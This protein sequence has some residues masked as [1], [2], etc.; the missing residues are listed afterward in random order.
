[1]AEW[2]PLTEVA[3]A[4]GF[5]ARPVARVDG[6]VRD[7]TR[8][9]AEVAAWR[10]AFEAVAGPRVALYFDDTWTF[11]CALYG[12]WHAGKH[13][14]LPGD[15]QPATLQRVLPGVD[16]CAG[17]LPGAIGPREGAAVTPLAA[18]DAQR[19]GLVVHTSGS[20]GEPVEIAKSLAQL[21]AEMDTLQAAFGA[22]LAARDGAEV[23]ATVSHQ[24]I[25]G[26]LFHALWPLASGRV[27]V[28][29]RLQYPE[30]MAAQLGGTSVL[31]TSPA[32]LKRLPDTLD[33][34]AA[35]AGLLA[36][37]SSGGPLPPEAAATTLDLL[38]HSPTEVYGSSETG[39]IAWR[40]RAEHGDRWT[41]L[42][43]IDWRA[44]DEG[45]LSVRSRHLPD[46]AWFE[47]A[48]RVAADGDG[49][50][51]RGRADRIVKIEEKRVSLTA[52]EQA[53]LA[54]GDLAEARVIELPGDTG[55]RL[56]VVGVPT[57]AGSA[58]LAEGKRVLNERLRAQL[59]QVVERVVLP[60]RFRYLDRLPANAQGK[61]PLAT[62]QAL[63]R[64]VR[65][66]PEWLERGELK[67]IARLPIDPELL[68]FDGHFP[69][70]PI[71]PGVAQLDWA[72][73]FARECFAIPPRFLRLDVLK[74]QSPV[75]PGMLLTL[76]LTWR[77]ETG[78]LAFTY[79]SD[80][81]PHASGAVV[82]GAA[83]A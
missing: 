68:V 83:D 57:P 38:G 28:A 34:S 74:F 58:R 9:L 16:A 27:L 76:T 36:V 19:T 20:S 53:L 14:S 44:G 25:Y 71:L 1:M 10:A 37:F 55:P 2:L 5:G 72:V 29:H 45:Q 3:S 6:V 8:F 46:G 43:G 50:V 26:L 35:R 23:F 47:T 62:L 13:V 61:T 79:T 77:P 39:G 15:T 80:A 67:A 56:A 48:D 64:P 31:V 41:P 65:P 30:E 42:P 69:A 24:H 70:V 60:R 51:L 63:F 75:R 33:W 12:A 66:E 32:H 22:Q 4:P 21:D 54:G 81:G 52:M 49:F 78:S 82:F 18:L 17:E 7:R 40:R 59:L 73:G 11:A